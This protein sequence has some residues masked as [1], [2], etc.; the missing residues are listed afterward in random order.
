MGTGSEK[1]NKMVCTNHNVR[2]KIIV[3]WLNILPTDDDI[4]NVPKVQNYN[5]TSRKFN[6][7]VYNKKLRLG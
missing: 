2:V 3:K 4:K 6:P 1:V 5:K 7:E